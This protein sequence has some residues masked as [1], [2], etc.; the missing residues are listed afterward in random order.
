SGVEETGRGSRGSSRSS[1]RSRAAPAGARR[2]GRPTRGSTAVR[3]GSTS[4]PGSATSPT[5]WRVPAGTRERS[6]T[7][8]SA[9][10]RRSVVFTTRRARNTAG[11]VVTSAP[12]HPGVLDETREAVELFR[13]QIVL[14]KRQESGDGLLRR[15]LEEGVREALQRGAPGAV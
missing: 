8:A 6:R 15:A 5:R 7:G 10:A 12:L 13:R 4:A 3:R 2:S 1:T 11:V 14:R 9:R